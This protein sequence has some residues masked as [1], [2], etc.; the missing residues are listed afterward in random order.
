MRWIRRNFR[1]GSGACAGRC[2]GGS[3]AGWRGERS[4]QGTRACSTRRFVHPFHGGLSAWVRASPSRFSLCATAGRGFAPRSWLRLQKRSPGP[5]RGESSCAQT[6]VVD[7]CSSI[8]PART[9]ASGVAMRVAEIAS[10]CAV[11]AADRRRR[12]DL[13][14]GAGP[15]FAVPS[16]YANIS[17]A[18]PKCRRARWARAVSRPKSAS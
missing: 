12:R 2:A 14:G 1:T 4:N 7:G 9:A 17:T 15:V 6:P 16:G 13:A 3:N 18:A 5:R 10:G 8:R 11:R